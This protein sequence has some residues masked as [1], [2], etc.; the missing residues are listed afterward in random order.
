MKTK[1]W[2][3]KNEIKRYFTVSPNPASS[4]KPTECQSVRVP[5]KDKCGVGGVYVGPTLG[6]RRVVG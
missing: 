5:I 3:T 6:L 2:P 1:I 4:L